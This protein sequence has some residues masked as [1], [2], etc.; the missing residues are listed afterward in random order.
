MFVT[1]AMSSS[2]SSS[3]TPQTGAE[4]S[5]WDSKTKEKFETKSKSEFYDPCQ[6]A[7]QRSYKCLYRN[8][9]DKSMCGEYFQNGVDLQLQ[10]AFQDGNWPVAIRLAEKR[11]RTFND[12]YFEIV[13][14]CSESQL[15]DPAAKFAAVVAVR[16]YVDDGTVVKDVDGIDLL[17]WATLSLVDD[18]D[19][20]E[21][22]GPLRVRCVKAAP[23]DKASA[24]RC[25][26]S[27]LLH[28]DLVSA[29]QI[30]AI[31]DRSFP[32]ER[33][34][35]FWNIVITHLLATST[36]SPPEKKKLYGML[37][38]KQ[39]ERAAQLTEQARNTNAEDAPP[40]PPA[41]SIRTE[42]EILLLYDV[43]EE[44]GSAAD[45]AKLLASPVF[46]PVSQFRLGR[47]ELFLR[48]VVKLRREGD[49]QSVFDFCHECLSDADE[50]DEP[51]LLASDWSVWRH[52]I[53]A[54]AQL[55][56]VNPET[57]KTVQELLVLLVK[58]KNLRPMYKR[59]LLLARVAAAFSLGPNDEDDLAGGQPSS[60]RLREMISYINHQKGSLA[61]FD[62]V[63][64]FV[65][66][67]EPSAIKHLAW[68]YVPQLASSGTDTDAL[69][70]ARIQLL[71]LKLQYF[72]LTC[73]A[74]VLKLPGQKPRSR[75]AVCDAE[76]Q[77]ALCASCLTSLAKRA[78]DQYQRNSKDLAG[79]TA[80][81][82]EVG[83][84]LAMVVAF[85]NIRLALNSQLPGYKSPSPPSSRH[86]LRAM[87]VLE[88]QFHLTP[89]HSQTA[90]LLVQLHLRLG[91]AHRSREIWD[92]LA[93]KRTISDALAPI[94]Y[95]RLSTVSPLVISPSDNW[96]VDLIDTLKQHYAVSLKLK[97]PRRLIDAF[98]AGSYGSIVGMPRYIENL[99]RSCTRA[100]S[101]VEEAR[102]ERLFGQPF[103]EV[104]TDPRFTQISDELELN[105]LVDYGSFASWDASSCVPMHS[106][107]SH[108]S[109]L[110]EA[111]H[112]VLDHKPPT[113]YKA[114]AT[115]IEADNTFVL[116]T[117]AQLGHSMPKFLRSLASK[118]TAAEILYFETV[119]LLCTLIP[120]CTGISRTS[121]LP[122]GLNQLADSVLSALETLRS[123]VSHK[124]GNGVEGAL[125]TMGSLH[126]MA[127]L[128][129]TATAVKLTTQWI[130]GFNEREKERDRSGSSNLHKEVM[131]LIK[132]MESAAQAALKKG[133]DLVKS[134][135][136][137]VVESMDF[138]PTLKK[139]VFDEDDTGLGR[140]IEDGTVLELARSLRSNIAGWQQVKWD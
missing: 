3:S 112:D 4:A 60:L 88:H 75:C 2:P 23:K 12:Q 74:S 45:F 42:E 114:S 46:S 110:S 133:K 35:L 119:S 120:L 129:D 62:D 89:K 56:S 108:L 61:C 109:L 111:F 69:A 10:S 91:S 71:C 51:T 52:F 34:F 28:W 30:A 80:A 137:G 106:E 126:N 101:L 37:A 94:F 123:F 50:N 85:C 78:L 70:T 100:M 122:E 14:I 107:R 6:E 99:R 116:E 22:L 9:G 18:D 17:E 7:A 72:A 77:S 139:W 98:E 82:N 95:D 29:Q 8:G 63:K 38:Q 121:P 128:R 32:A 66:R 27:C 86:L 19:F 117:M 96:G 65:E 90:L 84:E 73:L 125:S 87:F 44:H 115:A 92:E 36:Q 40:T 43:V 113:V 68:K 118:C 134:W 41:R 58:S 47:K 49:W 24:T 127:L 81:E 55:K 64:G 76:F 11:W 53:D 93:V 15:D 33:S 59:N 48:V 16:K 130:Q 136:G 26:E 57:S 124:E 135:D 20:P 54:A 83:P 31:I 131:A 97:M 104:L 13:K 132:N 21:T 79:N 140:V 138:V 67:L 39:I 103:G 102:A 25:L 1:T 105:E 5:P